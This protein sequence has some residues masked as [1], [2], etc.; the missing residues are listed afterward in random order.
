M[1]LAMGFA[2]KKGLVTCA[3][4]LVEMCGLSNST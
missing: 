3:L 2:A 1:G 4:H